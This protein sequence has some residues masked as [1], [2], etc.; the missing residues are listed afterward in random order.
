MTEPFKETFASAGDFLKEVIGPG[1]LLRSEY[2]K[3]RTDSQLEDHPDI[4][5][6]HYDPKTK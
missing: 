1:I 6:Q 2:K 3:H 4:L 5:G